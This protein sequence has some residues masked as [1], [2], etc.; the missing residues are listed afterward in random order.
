[1]GLFGSSLDLSVNEKGWLI[2]RPVTNTAIGLAGLL[3]Q[4]RQEAV[5][6][7]AMANAVEG[8]AVKLHKGSIG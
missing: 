4:P 2:A 5:S 7:A 8:M 1:M 6:V 3:R